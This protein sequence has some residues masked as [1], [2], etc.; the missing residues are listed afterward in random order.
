MTTAVDHAHRPAKDLRATDPRQ[1]DTTTHTHHP[2]TADRLADQHRPTNPE[3]AA[4]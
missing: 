4:P 2:A 3:E 1:A